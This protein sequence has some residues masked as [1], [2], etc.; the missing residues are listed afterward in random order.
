MQGSMLMSG[1][2]LTSRPHL[3]CTRSLQAQVRNESVGMADAKFFVKFL[4]PPSRGGLYCCW[5]KFA[6]QCTALVFCNPS[7]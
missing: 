1:Q 5:L 4:L 3:C 7:S 6:S 2:S